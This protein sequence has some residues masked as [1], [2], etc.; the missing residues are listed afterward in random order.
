MAAPPNL[1]SAARSNPTTSPISPK[2]RRK[3]SA[4]ASHTAA[5]KQSSRANNAS[6]RGGNMKHSTQLKSTAAAIALLCAAPALAEDFNIPAGDLAGA[7]D[8]Y[9]TR[10]GVQL[11]YADTAVR[12][13]Q[14]K[15]VKGDI[16]PDTALT[17]ILNGTGFSVHRRPT[18][19]IAI[20]QDQQS[21]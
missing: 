19:S 16:A 18:G 11:I 6:D 2:W 21:S 12:G 13:I 10:T 5:T 4:C 17:R 8:L 9:A 3:S 15:G 20:V 14:T 7:L 1:K